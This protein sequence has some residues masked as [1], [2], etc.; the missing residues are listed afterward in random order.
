MTPIDMSLEQLWNELN[1]PQDVPGAT[2]RAAEFLIQQ[3]DPER[4][5]AW[6]I[7][8]SSVERKAILAHL[9]RRGG[10]K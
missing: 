5:R 4:L 9:E 8:R 2:L 3:K 10:K 6:L 7:K 1:A